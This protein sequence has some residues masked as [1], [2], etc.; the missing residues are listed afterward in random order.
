MK[1][2]DP[3]EAAAALATVQ[4]GG[5]AA[6]AAATALVEDG[7]VRARTSLKGSDLPHYERR[8]VESAVGIAV[9]RLINSSPPPNEWLSYVT[10]VSI[11]AVRRVV[12]AKKAETDWEQLDDQPDERSTNIVQ[13]QEK[14]AILM[15]CVAQLEEREQDMIR[16]RFWER[17]TLSALAKEWELP[18]AKSV[19]RVLDK[20]YGKLK[21]LL[22]EWG[23]TSSRG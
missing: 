4:A 9:A 5:P 2:L 15:M 11:N 1:A 3:D 8:E 23:I 20:S 18:H 22:G 19:Q 12:R 14:R 16:S 6:D 17:A 21:G 13:N 7:L 10:T